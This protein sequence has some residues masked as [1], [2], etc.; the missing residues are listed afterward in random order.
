[1]VRECLGPLEMAFIVFENPAKTFHCFSTRRSCKTS[2]EF[3]DLFIWGGRFFVAC[4]L[5]R[6]LRF[7]T[8]YLHHFFQF[9]NSRDWVFLSTHQSWSIPSLFLQLCKKWLQLVI[10]LNIKP[11]MV[12][13]TAMS[14]WF[15]SLHF[16]FHTPTLWLLVCT[17][18]FSALPWTFSLCQQCP[19]LAL[20]SLFLDQLYALECLH[21]LLLLAKFL[22][23]Y[24]SITPIA[25]HSFSQH[26]SPLYLLAS[27]WVV[28]LI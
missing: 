11:Y 20:I 10:L 16:S 17:S 27:F 23:H 18:P 4:Q 25:F 14:T 21:A 12:S 5:S 22:A 7:D 2:L 9:N 24:I 3:I 26:Y 19:R 13:I 1:M 28:W 6:R 15:F 8:S